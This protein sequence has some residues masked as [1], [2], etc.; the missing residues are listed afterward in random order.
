MAIFEVSGASYS[1]GGRFAALDGVDLEIHEGERV[2]LMGANGSGKSTLLKMLDGLVFPDQGTVT[3]FGEE[4][5]PENLT[6]G[7]DFN[8]FFRRM[9][10][11]VFQNSD[12]QLFSP[13]VFDEIAFGPLQMGLS[14]DDVVTRVEDVIALLGIENLRDRAPYQLSGGEKKKVAIASVLSVNPDVL[15]LDEPTSGLDPRT[16]WW[17]VD[18]LGDLAEAGKTIITSTH[19]LA[20]VDFIAERAVILSED[21]KKVADGPLKEVLEDRELLSSVNLIHEHLH[22]HDDLFHAHRHTHVED[23]EHGHEHRSDDTH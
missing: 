3:A 12:V 5:T 11:L 19:D 15:L 14:G 13:T 22:R 9:V 10:G 1:Y 6:P 2:A 8:T 4:L 18:I 16:Q 20:I 17:L 7:T 23:D 21:H